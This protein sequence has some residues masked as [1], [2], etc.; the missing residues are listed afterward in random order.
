MF[1]LTNLDL[2]VPYFWAPIYYYPIYLFP[3][4]IHFIV[5]ISIIDFLIPH[6]VL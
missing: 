1:F 4:S 3:T 6:L 2:N 5:Y